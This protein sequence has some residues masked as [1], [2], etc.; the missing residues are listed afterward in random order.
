MDANNKHFGFAFR[1]PITQTGENSVV[2]EVPMV[3][4]ELL[5]VSPTAIEALKLTDEELVR[6]TTVAQDAFIKSIAIINQ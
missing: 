2:M 4:G 3:P 6:A 5:H 1:W